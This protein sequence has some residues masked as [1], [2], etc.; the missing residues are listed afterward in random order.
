[1]PTLVARRI[2]EVREQKGISRQD[3]ARRLNTTRMRIWRLE[4]GVTDVSAEDA[5]R[6]AQELEVSV[7]SLYR[8]SRAS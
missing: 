1:M 3:L 7:A 4:N 5:L 6:I 2:Q 8:E